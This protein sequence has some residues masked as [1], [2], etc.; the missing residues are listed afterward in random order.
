LSVPP[1]VSGGQVR[2]NSSKLANGRD[3]EPARWR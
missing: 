1:K 2:V 3:L